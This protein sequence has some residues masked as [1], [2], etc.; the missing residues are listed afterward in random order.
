MRYIVDTCILICILQNDRKKLGNIYDLIVLQPCELFVSVV[1]YWEI[2][3]KKNL[4]KLSAPNNLAHVIEESGFKWLAIDPM[5]ID[6]LSALPDYHNDP[7]DRL[8]I[9]QSKAT[10]MQLLTLDEKVKTYLV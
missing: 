9:A 7:F 2:A 6:L 4:G 8:L 1:S 3:I 10:L 5:H